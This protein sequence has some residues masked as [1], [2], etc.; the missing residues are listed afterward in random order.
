MQS[1]F[2]HD[3]WIIE[4]YY[5]VVRS[6]NRGK[7]NNRILGIIIVVFGSLVLFSKQEYA[8]I[9][10]AISIGIGTGIFF[11]KGEKGDIEN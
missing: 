2:F 7:M 10:S 5:V 8:W 11:R 1:L 3:I 6:V 9:I 4:L